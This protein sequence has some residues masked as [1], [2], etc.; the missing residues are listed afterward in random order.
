MGKTAKRGAAPKR[1][2][3]KGKAKGGAPPP[4]ARERRRGAAAGGDLAAEL[5]AVGLR[6]KTISA[7][8]NCAFHALADQLGGAAGDHAAIRG[9][10]VDHM[11][12]HPEDFSPFVEDDEPFVDYIERMR[13]DGEWA[14]NLELQAASVALKVNLRIY[15][16]GQPAW[17]VAN[18][19]EG[20]G[21]PTL[22]L[23]Y[24]GGCHYNSVRAADD[25]GD[26]PP[27][28]VDVPEAAA[29]AGGGGGEAWGEAEL[30]EVLRGT[31]GGDRGAA[32]A[33]LA[34]AGGYA[35]A[36]I[37]AFAAAAA[38][39]KAEADGAAEPE[40]A[41]APEAP[42]APA[43]PRSAHVEARLKVRD[44]AVALRL[45]MVE[46]DRAGDSGSDGAA[47]PPRKGGAA[48]KKPKRKGG[49][50]PARNGPCACGSKKKHKNCCGLAGA[51]AARAVAAAAE[52]GGSAS[53]AAAAGAEGAA[54][55]LRTLFI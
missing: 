41:P 35:D 46:E 30:E 21:A 18:W 3:A 23:A 7:D 44:G 11:A 6:V 37:E 13:G 47:A 34:R 17:A 24:E 26:G 14:G 39:A 42:A 29:A 22:R 19:P 48:A 54:R 27:A 45:R 40:A 28:V 52:R 43:A 53:A 51:A 15:Q 55:V 32:A 12:V 10:V 33:A 20:A 2:P 16:A 1:K 25:H 4:A 5:A 8:G 36:A 50:P 49:K 9:A 38:G 31:G